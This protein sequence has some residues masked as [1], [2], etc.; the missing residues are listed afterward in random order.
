MVFKN[1]YDTVSMFKLY[2]ESSLCVFN[3]VTETVEKT[4]SSSYMKYFFYELIR[5]DVECFN[6]VYQRHFSISPSVMANH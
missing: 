3:I 6:G 5:F 1:V 4:K 2:F